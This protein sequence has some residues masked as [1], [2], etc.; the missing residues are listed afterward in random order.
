M[1]QFKIEKVED[2]Y[3]GRVVNLS[4]EHIRLPSDERIVI[5]EVVKHPGSS[6]IVPLLGKDS[7]ILVHQFRYPARKFLWEIPAGTLEKGESPEECAMREV[8][9]ES[10]YRAKKLKKLGLFYPSPGYCDEVIHLFQAFQLEKTQQNL[11]EEEEEGMRAAVF[12]TSEALEMIRRG[13]IV[14]A[15][16]IIGLLWSLLL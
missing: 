13:E 15:K 14:D 7:V 8:E 16:S 2:I 3:Q 9:E 6:A 4:R 11:Q 5:R 10:G 12:S 1:S